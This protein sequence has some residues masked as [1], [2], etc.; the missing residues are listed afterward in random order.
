[1]KLL[2][3]LDIS[4]YAPQNIPT[5]GLDTTGKTVINN[6]ITIFLVVIIIAALFVLIFA[7][8]RWIT[9][10]GDKTKIDQARTQ[11]TYA[12]IG[13]VVAFLS[14]LIINIFSYLFGIQLFG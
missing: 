9:S 3:D 4:N 2:A 5:G 7:G 8:I 11:I 1:M 14:F 12:I 13:L 6:G 10:G